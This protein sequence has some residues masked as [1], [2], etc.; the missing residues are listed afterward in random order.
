MPT[1][2]Q[3]CPILELVHAA[4]LDVVDTVALPGRDARYASVPAALDARLAEALSTDHPA[5]LYHHQARAIDEFLSGHDVC[6]A[7]ST[8]SGK[9][10]AFITCALHVLLRDRFS[11]VLALYPA[12]A[13]IQD[14]LGKWE[15][16][17]G[18]YGISFAFIDGTVPTAQR[19]ALLAGARVVL[20]TPDVLHAWLLAR[21][22]QPA[23]DAFLSRLRV[24]VLDEA[25][26]YDGVFGSN[27][28]YLLRR[29]TAVSGPHRVFASTATI[30]EPA[31]FLEQLTGRRLA[32][33]DAADDGSRAPAKQVLLVRPAGGD[34]FEATV[35]LLRHLALGQTGRFLAFG[36]S[37]KMAERIVAATLRARRAVEDE[38]E[39]EPDEPDHLP[40]EAE[41][42]PRVLPYRAGYE[43]EDRVA[44]QRALT[45]GALAGVV[46]T[47]ALEMG[48]DIGDIDIVV[49]LNAPMSTRSLWQRLGRAGRRRPAVCL[50]VDDE[51][52][53]LSLEQWLARP[54]EQGWL[55][56]ENR[57][58]Q[59]SNALAAAHELGAAGRQPEDVEVFRGLPASFVP[60]VSNELN[61]VE[62]I[63]D[64][65]Y[66][67]KQRATGDPHHEF[68]IRSAAEREFKVVDVRETPLGTLSLPQALREAYPGAVYYYMAR[69]YRVIAFD[70]QR[71]VIRVKRDRHYTTQPISVAMVFPR[72]GPGTFR[73]R[74]S[75]TAL[76]VETE[77]QVAERVEGY[78][79]RRGGGR[80]EHRY[81]PQSDVYRRPLSRFFQTTGVCWSFGDPACDAVAV[82]S[83][84]LEAFC[85]T[86][87]IQSRDLGV[88]PFRATSNPM[89]PAA[90]SGICIYDATHGS[91]RLTEQLVDRW[92]EVLATAIALANERGGVDNITAIT[93]EVRNG[94]A[95]KVDTSREKTSVSL[96][97]AKVDD[98]DLTPT[99]EI[100][101]PVVEAAPETPPS[102]VP[103][104]GEETSAPAG[105]EA[106]G[107][108]G[109]EP[110]G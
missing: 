97:A 31:S 78:V 108:P 92:D 22:G 37:R 14:Q 101:V 28:A 20:M 10:L 67:I 58:I 27:T 45:K 7:T 29:L 21:I 50:V 2:P 68:P 96:R 5:G 40:A 12:K 33:I 64:D 56:L 95:K 103:A 11:R 99:D 1:S 44:I 6:L 88:G 94:D 3:P 4:G 16:A 66:A 39:T 60:M 19:E 65:L 80:L 93:V 79:E 51:R 82:A 77:L 110:K 54:V 48:I 52:R 61:P 23:V 89:L 46:S 106:E 104:K 47:S 105:G 84:V 98:E 107:E 42:L 30:G 9:S 57:F 59:Y 38:V 63:P 86:C 55:Y 87:G 75:R 69:P 85:L 74:A 36:A 102:G 8:A 26:V 41:S 83:A 90:K 18:S 13:L 100:P 91:L 53:V 81:G 76:L 34:T 72:F 35:T 70:Y 49:L 73:A 17:L 62:Q 32:V 109:S 24:L 15:A 25:H 71:G 43:A